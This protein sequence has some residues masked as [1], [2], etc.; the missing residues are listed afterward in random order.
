MC[1]T[2]PVQKRKTFNTAVYFAGFCVTIKHCVRSV[3][4]TGDS[5]QL[6]GIWKGKLVFRQVKEVRIRCSL[7]SFYSGGIIYLYYWL[8]AGKEKKVQGHSLGRNF[9]EKKKKKKRETPH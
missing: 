1:W 8:E 2:R 3:N 5:Q 9:K 4:L 7:S 6:M